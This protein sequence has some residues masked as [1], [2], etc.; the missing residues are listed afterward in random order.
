MMDRPLSLNGYA[1]VEGNV[2]NRVDPSGECWLSTNSSASQHQQC[3]EAWVNYASRVNLNDPTIRDLM[4]QEHDYWGYLPYS[5]F[6]ALWNDNQRRPPLS[7]DP[8]GV[9][10]QSGLP[11]AGAISIVNPLLGPEDIL[12]GIVLVCVSGFAVVAGVF[13]IALRQRQPYYFSNADVFEGGEAVPIPWP[14][15][16][17]ACLPGW[18]RCASLEAS[19]GRYWNFDDALAAMQTEYYDRI[20][21]RVSERQVTDSGHCPGIGSHSHCYNVGGDYAGSITC[22]PCCSNGYPDVR[23]FIRWPH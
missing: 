16:F 1:W 17:E 18:A 2:V 15:D 13:A 10:L 23:C 19:G 20:A 3:L 6:A 5:E 22:C 9:V 12:A 21:E 14:T 4:R 7:T 11:V 8:G